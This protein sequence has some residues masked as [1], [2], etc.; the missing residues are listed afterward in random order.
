MSAAIVS[1]AIVI[2]PSTPN[3]RRRPLSG[4]DA[5]TWNESAKIR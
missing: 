1:V 3:L 4:I 2:R 5:L